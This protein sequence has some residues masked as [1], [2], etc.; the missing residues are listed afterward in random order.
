MKSDLDALIIGAGF[1]GLGMAIRLLQAGVTRLA[2]LEQASEIGG[3]WRDNT[4]PGCACDIPSHLYSWSFEPNPE[5]TRMYP[6]QPEIQA[7]LLRAIEHRGLRPLIRLN[8]Q[9]RDAVWDEAARQWRVATAS[10]ET[11]TAHILVA[12]MGGLSR[13]AYPDIPGATSFAGPAFHSARWDH[14]LNL[15][16][17]RVA[18]IGTGASAIQFVPQIA[19]HVERLTL[20][21]R[22]PPWIL[23]KRDP[24]LGPFWRGLF[25]RLPAVMRLFRAALY[26]RQEALAPAF[27]L[28]PALMAPAARMARAHLAAA[29][30]DPEL[31][32]KL[33]PTY[34]MGCKRILLSND[35]Y[36]ALARPNVELITAPIDRITPSGVV[37]ADGGERPADALIYGTGFRATDLLTPL[38]II[39]RGGVD[40]NDAWRGGLE[41]YHGVTV[42]GFPNLFILVGPNTGLGHNS[43][44]FIIEAQIHY[45]L[46]CLRLMELR[47]VRAIDVKP[48]AQRRYN[49]DIQQRLRRTV[50]ASGC[51]SWYLDARGANTT[52]WPGSTIS[53][54]AQTREPAAADYSLLR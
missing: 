10:G 13:P 28:S 2:I 1:A 39:G 54:W 36:P 32:R 20:Y 8:C 18:V 21:Q 43:I 3:T 34:R 17:K 30:A 11:F 31:R 37:T 52:L 51:K 45:V 9:V 50:W 40:L 23:P 12:G 19:P 15:A 48:A 38:R 42:T 47:G 49:L 22:T 6:T 16:G 26:W 44:V 46:E 25:R 41:A 33:T 29:V 53:Y 27:T 24:A 5:W 7:Y 14:S 4:Y 35:Y